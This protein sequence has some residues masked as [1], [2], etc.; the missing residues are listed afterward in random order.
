LTALLIILLLVGI[1]AFYVM[2]EYAV[3]GVGR[4]RARSLAR[5]GRR[6]ARLL[7]PMVT[8]P[9]L[10]DRSITACQIG[11]SA[12]SLALGAYSQ[13]V[14][15]PALVPYLSRW[16]GWGALA[17]GSAA[18]AITLGA[19]S[20]F[21]IVFGEQVPKSIAVRDPARWALLTAL[22][23]RL[24]ALLFSGF[25][26][27]LSGSANLV[28]R[29][30][31]LPVLPRY[32]L[33]SPTEIGWIVAQSARTGAL[34]AELGHRLHNA[35]Q[36]ARRT[37]RDVMVPRVRVRA[38]PESISLDGL[39]D[40]V[41]DSDHTRLPVYR[42]SLDTIVGLVHT[43]DVLLRSGRPGA[44]RSV[45]ELIRPIPM[46]PQSTPAIRLLETMRARQAAMAV[47]LDEHGGT[48]GVVTLEDLVEEVFGEVEDEFDATGPQIGR[49]PDGCLRLRAEDPIARVN[50]E[51]GLSLA[52]EEA[53]TVGGFMME[54]L[55]RV[56]RPGDTVAASGYR[57]EVERVSGRRIETVLATPL[58]DGEEIT[59][60]DAD[61]RRS[62][63]DR[64]PGD[65]EPRP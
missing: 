13:V 35:L 53:Y 60:A 15:A 55:E 64:P 7:E 12:S 40:I 1:N 62:R 45:A 58:P 47:I 30:L 32:S 59:P 20:A 14:L 65:K 52:A 10:L 56:A 21:Q 24:S 4:V 18:V 51:L 6:G 11:I 16:G 57:L 36:F 33:H 2:A 34:Q 31:G 43:K 28:L 54:R 49:L 26:A 23:L 27:I 9:R 22:P 17:V 44:P 8:D 38:V 25:I 39:R 29:L 61:P 63:P 42:D 5:E 37:A 46:I 19:T 48:A 50:A 3:V 41:R